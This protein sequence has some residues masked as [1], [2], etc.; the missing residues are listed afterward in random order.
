MDKSK[1]FA[2]VC[3]VAL[4]IYLFMYSPMKRNMEQHG[5]P[6]LECRHDSP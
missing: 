1:W 4:G 2:A 6:F 3:G 5:C